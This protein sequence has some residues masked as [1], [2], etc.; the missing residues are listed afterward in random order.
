MAWC[1]AGCL[2]PLAL[3]A[4]APNLPA[5]TASSS[6]TE[7]PPLTKPPPPPGP[8][9]PSAKSPIGYF[10][11]LLAMSPAQREQALTNRPPKVRKLILAKVREYESLQPEER[12]LRL[13]VTELR[14]YLRPLMSASPTNRAAQLA[15]IPEPQRQLV[16]DRLQEWDNLA[17]EV[18][19]DLLEKEA[20]LTYLSEI[21]GLSDEQRR[22]IL[23][24]LS[25]ARRELL[26]KGINRWAAMS[27][28][29]RQT[30]LYRFNRFFELTAEE[31]AKALKTL[32]APERGQIEKTVLIF[33]NLPP[34]QRDE[35]IRSFAK[36][37][38]MSLAERQ[39]FF[40]DVERWKKMS[41]AEQQAWRELVRK[42]PRRLPPRPPPPL[43]PG[44]RPTPPVPTMATNGN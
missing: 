31:K 12:E 16:A 11:E 25:P 21:Q 9:L 24:N 23:R 28:D 44:I 19:K 5:T 32:S 17:P 27:E 6:V 43:P 14:W 30:T 1:G 40:K 36:F 35:C 2:L 42:L 34:N 41:P 7:H 18:Q 38:S 20:T 15:S 13:Q 3:A 22:E 29:Q 4:Q 37:T 26:E 33:G 39:Q 10:R 8:V